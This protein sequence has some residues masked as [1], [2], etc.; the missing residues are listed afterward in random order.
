MSYNPGLAEH[1]LESG[2]LTNDLLKTRFGA[3]FVRQME[4]SLRYA[5]GNDSLNWRISGGEPSAIYREGSTGIF[6]SLLC[7]GKVWPYEGLDGF[8]YVVITL[9]DFRGPSQVD[10]A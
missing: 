3:N 8:S 5:S 9:A 7:V 10:Q 2:A 4:F 1:F 6:R